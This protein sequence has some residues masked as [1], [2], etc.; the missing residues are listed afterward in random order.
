MCSR[1][2]IW[3]M[4]KPINLHIRVYCMWELYFQ[5]A[6]ILPRCSW[7]VG[8]S[9]VWSYHS[10]W[11][12]P[13]LCVVLLAPCACL[14]PCACSH[15]SANARRR[16]FARVFSS[17]PSRLLWNIVQQKSCKTYTRNYFTI[18]LIESSIYLHEFQWIKLA[19]PEF[20]RLCFLRDRK[21]DIDKI[22]QEKKKK[23]QKLHANAHQK[24]NR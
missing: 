20:H 23:E 1:A 7:M 14:R 9:W 12:S 6:S 11:S 13:Y 4:V 16:F 2:H 18:V 15:D 22:K 5:A 24:N 17:R 10:V 3:S 8:P 21:R 19:A